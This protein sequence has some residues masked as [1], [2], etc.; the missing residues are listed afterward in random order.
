MN[1]KHTQG[2][3]WVIRVTRKP[4]PE[5]NFFLLEG[6]DSKT[7]IRIEI[8]SLHWL[9]KSD[10]E[11]RANADLIAAAPELLEDLESRWVQTKC[12]CGHPACNRCE[13]DRHTES[14]L[15]KVHGFRKAK[16]ER[17]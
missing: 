16:E 17:E 4:G 11:C 5:D 9:L 1:D 15:D 8:A 13:D 3:W 10:E 12:G 6:T 2:P 7:G 14:I